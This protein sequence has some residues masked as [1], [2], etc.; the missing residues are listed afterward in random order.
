M[1]LRI[2]KWA[3][4]L[5]VKHERARVA[6][7]LQERLHNNWSYINTANNLMYD[8]EAKLSNNRKEKLTK[9]VELTGAVN[10]IIDDIMRRDEHYVS[11]GS[12]LFPEE[13]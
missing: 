1:G 10:A 3:Y 12:A 7:L 9:R 5:G 8:P 2:A 4:D 13:K 11:M 6:G